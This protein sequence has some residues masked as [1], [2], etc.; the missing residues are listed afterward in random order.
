MTGLLYATVILLTLLAGWRTWLRLRYFIHMFQLEGYRRDQMMSWLRGEGR[1][2]LLSSRHGVGLPLLALLVITAWLLPSWRWTIALAGGIA[3]VALFGWPR[4]YYERREKKPL[5]FTPRALRLTAAS[6]LISLLLPTAGLWIGS[7][8]SWQVGMGIYFLGWLLTDLGTFVWVLGAGLVTEPIERRIHEG[9]KR[10]A[11]ARLAERPDL[12]V[13]GIT[14]SFGKTSTKHIAAEI[15]GQKYRVLA[16]PSSYNTP[17]GLCIVINEMLESDHQILVLEMGARYEGDIRELCELARPDVSVVTSVGAAHLETL[18]TLDDVARVKSEIVRHMS[19]EGPAV[20]NGDDPRVR[21]MADQTPDGVL[22]VATSSEPEVESADLTASNVRFGPEGTKFRVHDADGRSVDVH[23]RLLGAH[24]VVNVLLAMAVG[25]IF[26]LRLREMAHAAGRLEPIEHRLELKSDGPVT[27]I[28]D[29]FNANPVGAR[30]AVEILGQFEG[31]RR[32]IVTPGL[33]ELGDEQDRANR[34]L[35]AHIGRH[36]DVALL[37]G[38]RQTEPIR[39]GLE[40]VDFPAE[41][42]RVFA[43]LYEAREFLDGFLEEGDV[44]LYENDLPDQY[45]EVDS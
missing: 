21:A 31:G 25:R 30:N 17:M 35:G 11:R 9:F 16:S 24:N 20:L 19:P 15:L 40:D 12:T 34:E 33:I 8:F 36:V 39:R 37:I 5:S 27:V 2:R 44:V 22:Q 13:V 14:G 41:D 42:V 18:G 4:T 7:G 28:D 43:S 1:H 26:D 10:R 32:V 6:G 29:A 23:T 38:E 45:A 3:T